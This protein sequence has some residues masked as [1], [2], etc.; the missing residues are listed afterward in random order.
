MTRYLVSVIL[1]IS[2]R[3]CLDK[4]GIHTGGLGKAH[5]L[6]GMVGFVQL[7]EGL[8]RQKAESGRIPTMPDS[9]EWGHQCPPA[10]RLKVKRQLFQVRAHRPSD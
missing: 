2:L 10:F 1:A 9:L 7:V 8:N 3:V 4:T 5:A 6:P